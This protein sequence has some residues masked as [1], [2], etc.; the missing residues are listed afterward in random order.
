MTTIAHFEHS[1]KRFFIRSNG[2]KTAVFA[3]EEFARILPRG[4]EKFTDY[5]S[6]GREIVLLFHGINGSHF[7]LNDL[8]RILF[9]RGFLPI[10]V[11]LPGHG[12]SGFLHNVDLQKLRRWATEV[13]GEIRARYGR[14]D[15][16]IAHSFGCYAVDTAS[17]FAHE[18]DENRAHA[19]RR[20]EITFICPVPTA[21]NA[22]KV[23]ASVAPRILRFQAV[24]KI[25]NY[26]PF[27]LWRG[28][29]MLHTQSIANRRRV[30]YSASHDAKMTDEQRQFQAEMARKILRRDIFR[31]QKPS[32]VVAGEFDFV[33]RENAKELRQIFPHAELTVLPT[34]HMPNV[35]L[36]HELADIITK[37]K[38]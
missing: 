31:G 12:D 34:G 7:G 3:P 22:A 38:K 36:P 8:A 9:D 17:I 15:K 27:S 26:V 29:K 16:I 20:P 2:V 21:L 32:K 25:Y 19:H 23:F 35:E 4:L 14:I 33:P 5:R 10:L 28:M 13:C 1:L 11:D 37:E 18:N 6:D 24:T 30:L